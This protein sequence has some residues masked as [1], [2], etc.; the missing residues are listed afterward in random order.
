MESK[1]KLRPLDF[2]PVFYQNQQMWFL[3]DPLHLTD[4][5]LFFPAAMAQLLAF[6]DG[7]HTAQ[8]IHAAFCRQIG[9]EIDFEITGDALARLDEACLLDNERANEA[10]ER[11]LAI[12]RGPALS[13]TSAGRSRVSG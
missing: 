2:Q 4:F 12:Y 9:V 1:P 11:L 3:R 8:E 10:K 5:Q 6:V 7:Q 13:S